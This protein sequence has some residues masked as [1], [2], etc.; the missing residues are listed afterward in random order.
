MSEDE[1]RDLV[2]R[3]TDNFLFCQ[4]VAHLNTPEEIG[5]SFLQEIEAAGYQITRAPRSDGYV[6]APGQTIVSGKPSSQD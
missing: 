6:W 5:E 2:R 3:L 4:T 1:R